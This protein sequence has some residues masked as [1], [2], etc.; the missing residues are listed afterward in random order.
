[1]NIILN[2]IFKTQTFPAT[3]PGIDEPRKTG[4]S[5]PTCIS[6]L[7][8]PVKTSK[9]ASW[10]TSFAMDLW[11]PIK[12]SEQARWLNSYAVD[13]WEPIKTSDQASWL[14][15][16]AIDYR[17]SVIRKSHDKNVNI[18]IPPQKLHSYMPQNFYLVLLISST[19]D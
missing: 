15:S 13:L 4:K 14:T 12:T 11:K 2:P 3:A 6:C 1:M 19:R 16:Y 7:W 17:G 18:Y 10:L 8:E 5:G 9:Q